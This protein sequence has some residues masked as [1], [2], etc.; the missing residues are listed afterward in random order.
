VRDCVRVHSIVCVT[1][2]ASFAQAVE[3][4]C[5][6]AWSRSGAETVSHEELPAKSWHTVQLTEDSASVTKYI[7]TKKRTAARSPPATRNPQPWSRTKSARICSA[8]RCCGVGGALSSSLSVVS[9]DGGIDARSL[10]SAALP[11]VEATWPS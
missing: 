8:S 6:I 11:A 2:P 4:A 1:P 7:A 9:V 3:T 10:G 5:A